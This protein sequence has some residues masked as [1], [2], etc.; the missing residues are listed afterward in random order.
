M[1]KYVL[2]VNGTNS[3]NNAGSKAA[4]DAIKIVNEL[5]YESLELYRSSE[6]KTRIRDVGRGLLN[7]YIWR[8]KLKDNDVIFFSI[9]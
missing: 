8:K 6:T 5:G 4:N 2:T 9:L 3:Q 1:S 7:V